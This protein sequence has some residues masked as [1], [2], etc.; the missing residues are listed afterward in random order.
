M[1]KYIEVGAWID[2]PQPSPSNLT[3]WANQIVKDSGITCPIIVTNVG[4]KPLYLSRW[5]V[6]HLRDAILAL[7]CAGAT[8]VGIMVWP[9]A[10]VEAVDAL[11]KDVG[12]I[13]GEGAPRSLVPDFV[14]IDAEGRYNATGWGPGGAVL[15]DRLCDGLAEAQSKH[16]LTYLSVTAIPPRKGIRLQD[17]SLLRHESV[18]R[19][20]PQAYSQ[21]QGPNHWSANPYFRVG[22]IQ[23]GT[24]DTWS[25]LLEDGHVDMLVAGS[26]IFAQDHPTGPTGIEALRQAADINISL[27][28][29]R[30]CYW[31]FKHFRSASK[32]HSERRGFLREL[33][34]TLCPEPTEGLSF[35]AATDRLLYCEGKY[36]AAK[37][38]GC[39][40]RDEDVVAHDWIMVESS[41]G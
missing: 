3:S 23:R 11:V 32:L 18:H 22:P 6:D 10:T 12:K 38:P 33:S 15:A 4:V 21:Y 41:T 39:V 24:W 13:Y 34:Q 35:A 29:R 30:I 9:A 17:A 37:R 31:S 8:Q 14:C 36:K 19:A 2:G 1:T 28:Y 5:K 26:A 27:G 7:R 25:P 16:C 40:I 20:T